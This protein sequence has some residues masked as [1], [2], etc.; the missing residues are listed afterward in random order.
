MKKVILSVAA[1]TIFTVASFA[2]DAAVAIA[3]T[4]SRSDYAGRGQEES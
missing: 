1:L 4:G 3:T 2:Q